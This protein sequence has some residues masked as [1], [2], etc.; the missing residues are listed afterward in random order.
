MKTTPG[1]ASALQ[2][3]APDATYGGFVMF[4]GGTR[5]SH[6][7]LLASH[8]LTA[9][10]DFQSS[11]NAVYAVGAVADLR[12]LTYEA[13][14]V[15]YLEE[16]K[17]LAYHGDTAVW[18]TRARVA[19]EAVSG[20]PFVD[21]AGKTLDGEGV[22]VAVV[23]SGVNALHP[24]LTNRVA[25][26]LKVVCSTPALIDT[27]TGQCF[28]P[29]EYVSVGTGN[30]DIT[31]GHGT[32]VS[33]IVAGDG[34]QSTGPYPV[35][36]AAPNVKGTFTGVAP[37]S[38]LFVYS[39]GEAITVLYALEAWQHMYDN[40]DSFVPRIRVSN[41]SFGEDGGATY[42]PSSVE[43]AMVKALVG[44]GVTMV[45]SAGNSGGTGATD[46]TSSYCDDPTPGV[47]C[48]AN[49]ADFT[50]AQS[51]TGTGNRDAE[52]SSDSSRGLESSQATWP[53]IS[54]PGS[55][56]TAACIR[57]VEAV[58]STGII[59]ELRWLGFY[60]S[61][62]GTS[63]ASPHVAGIAA[64]MFQARPDLTP[65]QVEDVLQD[66]AHK[67]TFGGA[68]VSDGQNAGGTTSFDKGAGLADVP[69][70]LK[71]LS[72]RSLGGGLLV[73]GTPSV[74]ISAPA[75]GSV[76]ST[77]NFVAS[78][79][80]NDGSPGA[81]PVQ[82]I[83]DGD[84]GDYSGPGAADIVGLSAQ[85]GNGGVT[86]RLLVRDATDLGPTGSASFRVTQNVN[87]LP[88]QTNVT[89]AAT[90]ATP[91][92][93]TAPATSASVDGNAITFV[94]PYANL[95]N[96][97]A[98]SPAHNVFASSFIQAIQDYAPSPNPSEGAE[99][100][101]RP[102]AG[103]PYTIAGPQAP[104]GTATVKVQ[105]D[106]KR[107]VSATATGSSPS[108][109]W[110]YS[111]AKLGKGKHTLKATLYLDGVAKSSDSVTFTAK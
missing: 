111:L 16:D 55:F 81:A 63:M 36:E 12:A 41:Q 82:R 1:F 5:A 34:T 17:R 78:G 30:S 108:Y 85:E 28:G 61:I 88:F 39:T 69:A 53:D 80:A 7:A 32:H 65:G 76:V 75:A 68:Y 79:T 19:Q 6:A 66:S 98:G 42:D 24:D 109:S 100:N 13:G 106:K 54:A 44:K 104:A 62:S 105:L 51:P 40:Y 103:K 102:M 60:G 87:G 20:G 70:A 84:G 18:A 52:L 56:I 37:G 9:T 93:G 43:A 10:A 58:C 23:D 77:K 2:S 92:T 26:N 94:V 74:G 11:V 29:L 22:G 47:I 95:G 46:T 71:A 97:P 91:G 72:V 64:L 3:L 110:S 90:G 45:F 101:T 21:A 25:S 14:A 83:A 67:F 57:G 50:A 31:S 99:V 107:P 15:R 96:P 49:Y 35:A 8:N 4:D 38:K 73:P 89:L 86:Y 48:V 27:E 33:G 59:N